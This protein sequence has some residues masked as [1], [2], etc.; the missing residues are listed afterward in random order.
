MTR[1]C[2]K[3]VKHGHSLSPYDSFVLVTKVKSKLVVLVKLTPR[4]SEP[5]QERREK[6]LLG[7]SYDGPP[8]EKSPFFLGKT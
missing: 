6:I 4:S 2:P 8:V 5:T 1:V 7:R 3:L